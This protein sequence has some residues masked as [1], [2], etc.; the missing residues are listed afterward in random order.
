MVYCG[1]LS[2]VGDPWISLT[3]LAVGFLAGG[4]TAALLFVALF[5]DL[6]VF[7]AREF[8]GVGGP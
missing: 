4:I 7:V 5:T 2:E 1:L 6:V 8:C 3:G